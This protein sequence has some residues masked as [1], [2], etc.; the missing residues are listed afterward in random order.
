MLR[1]TRGVPCARRVQR[2]IACRRPDNHYCFVHD[3]DFFA[4]TDD[5]IRLHHDDGTRS[6]GTGTPRRLGCLLGGVVRGAGI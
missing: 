5:N 4:G 3:V 1:S 2:L 6:A